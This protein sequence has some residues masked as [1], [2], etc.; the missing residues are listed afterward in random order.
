MTITPT[1]SSVAS[2]KSDSEIGNEGDNV[3][4]QSTDEPGSSSET[5]SG[6][7]QSSFPEDFFEQLKYS[8][9]GTQW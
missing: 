1:E 5:S 9:T 2:V 6:A 7:S 8:L 3:S 4:V